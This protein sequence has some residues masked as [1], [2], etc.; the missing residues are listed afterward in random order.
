MNGTV[1]RT[2]CRSLLCIPYAAVVFEYLIREPSQSVFLG[3]FGSPDD[4]GDWL[5]LAIR[6]RLAFAVCGMLIYM[7]CT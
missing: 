3:C 7:E 1:Q 2:I 4:T 6:V 5:L